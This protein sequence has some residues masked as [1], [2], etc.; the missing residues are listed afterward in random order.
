MAQERVDEEQRM[1]LP[2]GIIVGLVLGITA[3]SLAQSVS[4]WFTG[5]RMFDFEPAF[6]MGYAAGASDMLRVVVVTHRTYRSEQSGIERT[7][8]LFEIQLKCFEDRSG[9]NLGQ[10]SSWAESRWTGQS[11]QAAGV[12]FAD[13]CK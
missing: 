8:R 5:A 6:R 9:G 13:A 12:L 1:R 7:V 3:S 11:N 10:F 2:I 4:G